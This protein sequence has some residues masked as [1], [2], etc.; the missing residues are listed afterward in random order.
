MFVGIFNIVKNVTKML[1]TIF[2]LIKWYGVSPGGNIY[3]DLDLEKLAYNLNFL[4]AYRI[5]NLHNF[6][7]CTNYMKLG[8]FGSFSYM[9]KVFSFYLY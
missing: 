6:L 5:R 7:T 3:R 9:Y 8:S 4:D 1:F 2:F